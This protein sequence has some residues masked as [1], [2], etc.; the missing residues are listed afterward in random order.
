MILL[1]PS[2]NL[3][4]ETNIDIVFT[5]E[6]VYALR[7]LLKLNNFSPDELNG[8][9]GIAYRKGNEIKINLPERVVPTEKMDIDLPGYAWD[10]LPYKNKPFDLYRSPMWHAEYDFEKRS[11]YASLQ[12]SLGCVFKCDFCA[13]KITLALGYRKKSPERCAE[14]VKH[15]HDLGFKEF[16]LADDIFTSDNKWAKNVCDEITKTNID[17]P[18]SCS[19]GIRVESADED[20]FKSLR[21][22]GC[23]RV[24]FGFESGNDEV[25][26]LF[27]KG[28]RATVDQAKTAVQTAR[29]AGIDTNGYF[30]LGLSPDTEKSMNDTIDFAR[31]IPLD[32]MKFGVAIAFPGT[33][34]FNDY[35]EKGL[36]RSFDWDEYMIY[37]D[38]D[39][40]AH[41]NLSYKTI[42]KFFFEFLYT[43]FTSG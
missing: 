34:M 26:K 39:L 27:G 20:L 8:I 38:K 11:P 10:L 5:N 36:V 22:S 23:Y 42:Q 3:K 13:S 14:E 31:S 2:R 12:T 43:W 15:M 33:K 6:G 28:G 16:M 37:T 7:N 40:F 24:S 18:W 21:K 35:V 19:N 9:K 30:M 4:K 29:A 32:M 25:L 17:M 1:T 41:K